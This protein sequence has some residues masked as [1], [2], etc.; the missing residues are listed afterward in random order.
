MELLS[1]AYD[2]GGTFVYGA[3]SAA[4]GAFGSAIYADGAGK[5]HGS[6]FLLDAVDFSVQLVGIG[7]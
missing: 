6:E 1:G 4:Q 2:A 7:S 5:L 3:C